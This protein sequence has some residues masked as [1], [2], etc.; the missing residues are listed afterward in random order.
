M[1]LD[2]KTGLPLIQPRDTRP[3]NVRI[4]QRGDAISV[5]DLETGRPIA[6]VIEAAWSAGPQGCRVMLVIAPQQIEV[7][8]DRAP[9]VAV[10]HAA[11][12]IRTNDQLDHVIKN[13][14]QIVVEMRGGGRAILTAQIVDAPMDPSP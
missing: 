10:E 5:V 8:V 7:E 1:K 9:G 2:P 14:E 13:G 4:T 11:R 6:G 3:V 12:V